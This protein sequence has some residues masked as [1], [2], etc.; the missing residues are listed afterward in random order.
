M[1]RPVVVLVALL[2]AGTLSWYVGLPSAIAGRAT[3]L[4][5]EP[6]VASTFKDPESGRTDALI[7]LM[8]FTLGAPIAGALAVVC[9]VCLVKMLEA[10]F[11]SLRIPAWCASPAVG[12]AVISVLYVTSQTW[13]PTALHGCCLAARACIVYAH[14]APPVIR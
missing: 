10:V 11:V 13:I 7:A 5:N 14:G 1:N 4:A 12:A 8:A 2:A 6:S 9:L 3:Q